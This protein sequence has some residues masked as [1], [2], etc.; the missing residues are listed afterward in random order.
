MNLGMNKTSES[1]IRYLSTR[2]EEEQQFGMACVD[3]GSTR[4]KPT[5]TAYPLNI[6]DHPVL[7]RS[8]VDGR[9][10]PEFQ[11][12]YVISGEGVFETENAKYKIKP[13]SM[14]LILPGVRHRCSLIPELGWQE[15]WVGFKGEYFS[16]LFE[17]GVLSEDSVVFEAGISN[18][19][20]STYN[21]MFDEVKAQRPVY[22]LRIGSEILSLIATLL[23]HKQMQEGP[24]RYRKLTEKAKEL[25][26]LNLYGSINLPNISNELGVCTSFLNKIFKTY[27]SMTPYQYYI[28]IKIDEAKKLLEHGS[29]TVKETAYRLGFEDQYYFSRLFKSKTGVAPKNWKNRIIPPDDLL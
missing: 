8:V 5:N 6:N 7:Y 1:F 21:R 4:T 10:L 15:Y 26:A 3:V 25:M 23:N 20:I 12:G 28:N 18:H 11:I 9:V 22:Q 16:R 14:T 29:I 27:T 24:D 17:E 19:I 13:G 2:A